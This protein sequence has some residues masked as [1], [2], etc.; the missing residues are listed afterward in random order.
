MLEPLRRMGFTPRLHDTR[1]EVPTPARERAAAALRQA[2]I[3][4]QEPLLALAPGARWPSKCWLPER[5]VLLAE[6]WAAGGRRVVIVGGETER[7]L[8]GI[9]A[10]ADASRCVNLCGELD[11]LSTAEVLRRCALLVTNDSGLLHLSEAAGTPVVA[12]FG[13]TAPQF[14]YAPYRSDSRLL[15]QPPSCSPCS[16]NGSRPC[17]RP[18]HECME[19]L[20]VDAV[21]QAAAASA[22]DASP[23]A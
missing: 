2:G 8:G 13:P 5:F 11:L 4:P 18:T 14:G 10:L 22:P 17:L 16:K 7:A 1:L 9:V 6:R 12:L 21:W 15:R 23:A 19:A 20:T 3:D